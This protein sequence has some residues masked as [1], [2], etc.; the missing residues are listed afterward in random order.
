MIA[1]MTPRVF[2]TAAA[3]RAW[4][5]KNHDRATEIR[6]AYYKKRTGKKSMTYEEALQEALCFGWIDSTVHKI[7]AEKYA[8]RYTPRKDKSTWSAPN[9]RR[10]AAL[11]ASGRMAA[12]G[13]AKITTAKKNGSWNRLNGVER[14][15]RGGDPP[16]DFLEALDRRP[17]LKGRWDRFPPSQ[18]K[19][20]AWW[21]ESAKRPETR[22]RRIAAGLDM[23]E[24]GRRFGIESVCKT[25]AQS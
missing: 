16:Q 19:M 12:P 6:L 21:I 15:G 9:K 10:V 2:R 25:P 11:I 17:D 13:S 1:D 5:E 22:L 24:A 20:L 4:L 7:D 8:Q 18:K 23:I 3:W 14:I